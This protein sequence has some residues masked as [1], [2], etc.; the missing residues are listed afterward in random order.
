MA[1]NDPGLAQLANESEDPSKGAVELDKDGHFVEH[2]RPV[3][4]DQYDE[5]F[6]TG[7]YE[8]WAYCQSSGCPRWSGDPS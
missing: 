2:E 7:K 6:T 4:P 3:A 8:I 5:K 1:A